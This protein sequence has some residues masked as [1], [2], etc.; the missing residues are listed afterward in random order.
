MLCYLSHTARALHLL[1]SNPS[2]N[3][4]TYKMKHDRK[5]ILS[6]V[7]S[8]IGPKEKFTALVR[9]I[10]EPL[11]LLGCRALSDNKLNWWSYSPLF[12]C[13]AYWVF[14]VYTLYYHCYKHNHYVKALPCLCAF[15]LSIS[16]SWE[17]PFN[18]Q[19]LSKIIPSFIWK[20]N[21]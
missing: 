13:L 16:V 20:I 3:F 21:D 14:T 1:I 17:I 6:S 15:G 9:A 5:Q 7:W 11:H 10:N 2:V 12:V 19:I 4:H 8:T 18:C